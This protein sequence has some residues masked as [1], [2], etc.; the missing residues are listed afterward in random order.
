VLGILALLVLDLLTVVTRSGLRYANLARLLHMRDEMESQVSR[1]INMLNAVPRPQ[2]ALR[3]LQMFLRFSIAGLPLAF[4]PWENSTWAPFIAAGV[5]FLIALMVAGFEWSVEGLIS[6]DPEMWVLRMTPYIKILNVVFA[7]L[8]WVVLLLRKDYSDMRESAGLVTEDELKTLVDAGQQE[9]ILE[10]EEGKMIISIFQLGDTLTREIMVPRIDILALEVSTP[11]PE[12][13]DGLLESG[14][15][16]VPVFE[17]RVD[18]VLGL[19]YAK[20]ML[21]V[22]RAGNNEEKSLRSFLREAYFVP[23]AKK[24]DELLAE[25]Q[26]RRVHMAVVVDEYGGVA[27][28]VTLEDIIEEIFGEIQDEYD[29]EELPFQVVDEGDYLFQGRMD[30]DDFNDIM[31]CNLPKDQADTLSGFIYRRLGHVPITG[32]SIREGDLLMTVEQVSGR[33]IRQV[34]A[35]RMPVNEEEKHADG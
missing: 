15:S 10:Q 25:L 31:D 23:E 5:V 33:R 22:W 24:V 11:L 9:G 18:N 28:L 19:L 12:A 27:G 32:E 35:Q 8:V 3:I 17:E 20:D 29:E 1:T 16:R 2:I 13:M 30:L 14:Y 21:K 26:S 6:K 4:V 7:P 34:R